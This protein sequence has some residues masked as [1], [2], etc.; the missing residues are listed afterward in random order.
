MRV[1]AYDERFL[2]RNG[3][4]AQQLA[5]ELLAQPP[6]TRLPRI[7]DYAETLGVG[8]GTVQA[9]FTLLESTGALEVEARGHLGRYL[10]RIDRAQLWR[11]AGLGTLLAAMPLPY[12]RRYE[13]LATG[14]RAAFEQ[15]GI[16]FALTF[17]RGAQTRVAALCDGKCDL[18]VTSR[19]AYDELTREHPVTLLSDL[20][21]DTYV[22]AHGILLRQ[23]RRLDDPDLAV[24]VDAT[25]ADQ[26]QLTRLVFAD[27]AV[28]Y[29]ETSYMQLREL[30]RRGEV[31]ATVWN[32]DEIEHHLDSDVRV[33][34][35]DQ[36][37]IG[38]LDER[39][40][41]AALV[42]HSG[43]GSGA[44]RIRDQLSAR[45]ITTAQQE[46]LGGERI[47]SY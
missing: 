35:F 5:G 42:V 19:L 30:F 41:S 46:V 17:M 25:S 37:L 13:G 14:L 2:T 47:P 44:A 11:L 6:G 10:R 1:G 34:A 9:A 7:R 31:D 36:R 23:G 24:A 33:L 26:E 38:Q 20:G 3:L 8:N 43:A 15:A 45:T 29:V 27:R 39:N 12:S 28:R 40:R 32:L 22:G 18:V 4:T 16:P 21:P